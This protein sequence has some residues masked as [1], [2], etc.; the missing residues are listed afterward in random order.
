MSG[1]AYGDRGTGSAHLWTRMCT[2]MTTVE[3]IHRLY[4]QCGNLPRSEGQDPRSAFRTYAAPVL[5]P[6]AT[7]GPTSRGV[8]PATTA[9]RPA[10][11]PLR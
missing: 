7:R 4:P 3:F 8:D 5:L 10:T 11:G 6:G 2:R 9:L 1:V